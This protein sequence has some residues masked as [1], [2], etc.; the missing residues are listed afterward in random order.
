MERRILPRNR[1]STTVYL[2]VR[3][4][5]AYRCQAKNL[6]AMGV[7]LEIKSLGLPAGTVVNLVF[8]VSLGKIVRLHRKKAVVAH[9]NDDG[10]GLMIHGRARRP[11]R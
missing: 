9:V 8:A 4:G 11:R 5:R 2:A 3:N 7:F 6:S 1:V 10:A